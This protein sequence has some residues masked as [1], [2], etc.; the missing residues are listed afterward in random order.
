MACMIAKQAKKTFQLRSSS[1]FFLHTTH[2]A[3]RR[4]AGG[5]Y[6]ARPSAATYM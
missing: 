2:T 1:G 5:V 3:A 6:D 4:M